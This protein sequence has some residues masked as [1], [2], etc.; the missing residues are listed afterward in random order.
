M[1]TANWDTLLDQ[2]V[3]TKESLHHLHG[4]ITNPATLLLPTEVADDPD[5]T[6]D[7]LT[8]KKALLGSL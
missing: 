3:R 6:D 7:D 1:F 4:D 8:T 5:R 2:M